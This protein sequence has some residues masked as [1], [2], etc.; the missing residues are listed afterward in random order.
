M[1]EFEKEPS[2]SPSPW[3]GE[4]IHSCAVCSTYCIM[5][6][7]NHPPLSLHSQRIDFMLGT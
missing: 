2:L 1:S 7:G 5:R 4:V 3:K 6:T